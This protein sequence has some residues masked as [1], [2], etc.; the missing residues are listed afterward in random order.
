[1]LARGGCVLAR[2]VAVSWP[3]WWPYV[4]SWW[5]CL[6]P[7]GDSVVARGGCVV[8]CWWRYLAPLVGAIVM[9]LYNTMGP[10]CWSV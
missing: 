2:L 7:F 4:S 8:A 6:G 3:V 9:L 10:S 1:M 5:P